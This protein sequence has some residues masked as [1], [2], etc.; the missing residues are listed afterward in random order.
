MPPLVSAEP[1]TP[2]SDIA[3]SRVVQAAI[4]TAP[5]TLQEQKDRRHRRPEVLAFVWLFLSHYQD[6]ASR[7]ATETGTAAKQKK[8]RPSHATF[9]EYVRSVSPEG[10][11][12][13]FSQLVDFSPLRDDWQDRVVKMFNKPASLQ[14]LLSCPM[15]AVLESACRHINSQ[16]S[17]GDL[18]IKRCVKFAMFGSKVATTATR[19][20]LQ[21]GRDLCNP[22]ITGSTDR[23][24]GEVEQFR[25][26]F[27]SLPSSET[28]GGIVSLVRS[29]EQCNSLAALMV[30]IRTFFEQVVYPGRSVRV[31]FAEKVFEASSQRWVLRNLHLVPRNATNNVFSY[32]QTLAAWALIEGE[33]LAWPRDWDRKCNFECL[34]K[35]SK[36]ERVKQDLLATDPE[37]DEVLAKYLDA[38]AIKRKTHD[39][40][41]SIRDLYQHWIGN[42]PKPDKVHY[43]QFISV[44]VPIIDYVSNHEQLPEYGVFNIDTIEPGMPL[45]T[46]CTKPLLELVSRLTRIGM[47]A[48]ACKVKQQQE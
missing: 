20:E 3:A 1:D 41:L 18:P 24:S 38:E 27:D 16:L 28:L 45:L 21:S 8:V 44:P 6:C 31:G 5:R 12:T 40:S 4:E 15:S 19:Y 43:K 47:E 33:I 42:Q 48:L 46:E 36:F 9:I 22:S 30:D 11:E 29:V 2:L 37:V 7:I 32:P 23:L 39:E 25:E 10:L 17:E 13:Y 34:K 14:T 26:Q 35:L